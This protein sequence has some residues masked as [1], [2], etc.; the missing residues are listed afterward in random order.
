METSRIYG[1]SD[2]NVKSIETTFEA[3]KTRWVKE[4]NGFPELLQSQ[5]PNNN[6]NNESNTRAFI[7]ALE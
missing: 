5:L 4:K 6:N 1:G 2:A 7:I 3:Q